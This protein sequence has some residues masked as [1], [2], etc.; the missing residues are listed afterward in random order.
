MGESRKFT[1][2]IL[3]TGTIFT[4]YANGLAGFPQLPV[5]RVADLDQERARGAAEEWNIPAWGTAEEL[6]ADESIDIIVNITPPAAHAP[7]TDAALLAGKHVYTE[8][9]LAATTALARQNIATATE[10][11]RVLGGAPDTFLGAAGQT[12]RAAVDDGLIGTPFAATSFVR[13]SKVQRWHPDPTFLFQP[14]GGPVLD[15]GPYHIAALVNLLGPVTGVMGAS[16]TAEREITV[17]AAER[18]VE[19]IPVRVPTHATAILHFASGALATTM[20][21]FDVWDTDL[22]HIEVYGTE[23]TLQLPDPNQFDL[24]VR[25]KRRGDDAWRELEPAIA[26]TAPPRGTPFRAL[27]VVDLAQHLQGGPHRA[28][29]DF[30]YHVLDVLECIESRTP[31]SGPATVTSSVDRPAAASRE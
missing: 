31:E 4:A 5:M 25:I 9:P 2:G 10:T 26:P 8:K 23:G 6:L 30:A 16:T 1:V 21:S 11:A 7:L 22:P 18:R 13:S 3:G 15:W 27:G 14:G 19:T 28:S 24:P 29:A 20:Y 12:A 17:T